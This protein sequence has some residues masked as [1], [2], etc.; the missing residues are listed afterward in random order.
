MRNLSIILA[1]ACL[2][3][4]QVASSQVTGATSS[5]GCINVSSANAIVTVSGRLT[6]QLFAGRPNFTSIANGDAEVRSFIIELPTSVCIDDGGDFADPS[7]RVVTVHVSSSDDQVMRILHE[8]VGKNVVVT[9]E[10][11]AA[12]NGNHNAPLVILADSVTVHR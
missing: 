4:P 5:S 6:L 3:H 10:G 8:A 1:L 7:V 2:I 9:G 11:F 12:D